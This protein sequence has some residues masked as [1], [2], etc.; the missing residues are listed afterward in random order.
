MRPKQSGLSQVTVQRLTLSL[1]ILVLLCWPLANFQEL[2]KTTAKQG[3][4]C[5][6]QGQ[7]GS[8]SREQESIN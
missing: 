2:P 3:C 7:Q 1:G 6:Y 5:A 4:P 8:K